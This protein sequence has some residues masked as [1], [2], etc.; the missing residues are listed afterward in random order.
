[1]PTGSICNAFMAPDSF[2]LKMRSDPLASGQQV[3]VVGLAPGPQGG[4]QRLGLLHAFAHG[5][6]RDEVA[7]VLGDVAL[8]AQAVEYLNCRGGQPD[9]ERESLNGGLVVAGAVCERAV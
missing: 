4:L 7:G 9:G 8:F 5:T 1:M 3:G 6:V 2:I